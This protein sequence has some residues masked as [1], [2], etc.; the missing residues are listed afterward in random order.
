[1]PKGSASDSFEFV[2]RW[3]STDEL[4]RITISVAMLMDHLPDKVRWLSGPCG[5]D[6]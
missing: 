6:A 5:R 4:R 2:A 3:G 1:M